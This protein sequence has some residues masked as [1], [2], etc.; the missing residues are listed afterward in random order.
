MI[1]L[2][3]IVK[4]NKIS[5]SFDETNDITLQEVSMFIYELER[6]KLSM[7]DKDWCVDFKA[8]GENE[9]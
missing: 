4:D 1:K 2:G 5:T 9:E 7:L 3:M 6:I 8:E